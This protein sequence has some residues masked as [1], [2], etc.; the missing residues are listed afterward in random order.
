M[1]S[2]RRSIPG[3]ASS[4]NS[5]SKLLQLRLQAFIH[6]LRPG[7]LAAIVMLCCL[8]AASLQAQN[9]PPL[10]V[11]TVTN[12]RGGPLVGTFCGGTSSGGNC[13]SGAL[14]KC[15]NKTST[16]NCTLVQACATGCLS[17]PWRAVRSGF[18]RGAEEHGVDVRVDQ[19]LCVRRDSAEA[20]RVDRQ[21][22]STTALRDAAA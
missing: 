8:G 12:I 2:T 21:I 11:C 3:P 20:V 14:Y 16:N 22:A 10:Q 1:K 19:R 18:A 15:D 17:A 9:S 6:C 5:P 13:T 7:S 4:G